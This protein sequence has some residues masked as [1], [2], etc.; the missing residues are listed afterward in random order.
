LL[1]NMIVRISVRENRVVFTDDIQA[2]NLEHAYAEHM[3]TD[4]DIQS[5][6][7]IKVRLGQGITEELLFDTGFSGFYDLST[8]KFSLFEKNEG[9]NVLGVENGK[10]MYG[11]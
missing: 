1:R 10:A 9:V 6:P 7:V 5:S 2:V 4:K 11:M 8:Q 3:A